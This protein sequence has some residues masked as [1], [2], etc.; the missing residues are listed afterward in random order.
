MIHPQDYSKDFLLY[1]STSATA[2]GMVLSQED[3]NIQEHMIYY[4]SKNLLDSETRYSHVEKLALETVISIQKFHHY[5]LVCTTTIIV[6]QN[7]MYY[8]PTLRY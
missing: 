8:I 2:I 1:V 7:P 6:E 4:A 5:I 3:Q